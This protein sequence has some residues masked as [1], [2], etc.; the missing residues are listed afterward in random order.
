MA[1]IDERYRALMNSVHQND[2]PKFREELEKIGNDGYHPKHCM[3]SKTHDNVMHIIAQLG[4][5]DFLHAMIEHCKEMIEIMNVDGKTPL[6]DAA[7]FSQ[8]G[9][10]RILLNHQV[11]VNPIKRA[12]WTPLMLACTKTGEDALKTVNL[13]MDYRAKLD[14][15]NKV[16]IHFNTN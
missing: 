16:I 3:Y 13:L 10:V 11:N 2:F 4:R 8:Y 12:D 1:L 5:N 15:E 14:L 6:H 7:Q 9:I